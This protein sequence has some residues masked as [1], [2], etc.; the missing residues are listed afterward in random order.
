MLAVVH[1]CKQFNTKGFLNVGY[2]IECSKRLGKA[3]EIRD[4]P[5]AKAV[6][7]HK[8]EFI[9]PTTDRILVCVLHNISF[10]AAGIVYDRVEFADF[11]SPSDR[12]P[13]TWLEVDLD[14]VRTQNPA[15]DRMFPKP[16]EPEP[17]QEP[18][19]T[20]A[21]PVSIPKEYQGNSSARM[22]ATG[23]YLRGYQEG[24]EAA[25]AEATNAA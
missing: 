15:I 4:N 19:P 3:E 23:A 10:D 24:Y 25:L 6:L 8:P 1:K 12:R 9:D 17:K 13:K 20:N 14:W 2:Y 16:P 21:K 11:A 18:E 7:V 5:E 22:L